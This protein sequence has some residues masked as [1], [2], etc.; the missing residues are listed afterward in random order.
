MSYIPKPNP[1]NVIP[2]SGQFS[3]RVISFIPSQINP[4]IFI[5]TPTERANLATLKKELENKKF[6]R[7][8]KLSII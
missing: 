4:R 8:A 2:Y 7:F 1:V 5:K 6:T 3:E